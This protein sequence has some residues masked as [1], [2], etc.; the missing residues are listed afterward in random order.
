[1][2]PDIQRKEWRDLLTD[3]PPP[4]L[5]SLSFKLK[6]SSLKSN[7]KIDQITLEEAVEALYQYCA[8]NEKIYQK[9]LYIIFNQ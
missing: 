8:A 7:L 3:A 2:I 5:S 6:L 9:D 1:M 4:P